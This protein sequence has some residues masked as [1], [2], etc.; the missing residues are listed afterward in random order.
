[1]TASAESMDGDGHIVY[2]STESGNRDIWIMNADSTQR[3][4]LTND[5]ASDDSPA[6][7]ERRQ[8]CRFCFD[9]QRRSAS[10]ANE[11]ERRRTKTINR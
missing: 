11:F 7:S 4:Q 2:V 6:L 3:R 8:I 5:L 10:L 1:M 9:P